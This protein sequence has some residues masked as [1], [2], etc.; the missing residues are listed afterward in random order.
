M[1]MVATT[2]AAAIGGCRRPGRG[3]FGPVRSPLSHK[4]APKRAP[5]DPDR[6]SIGV[7]TSEMPFVGGVWIAPDPGKFDLTKDN[8][9]HSRPCFLRLPWPG[10][11][12]FFADGH[13]VSNAPDL[14]LTSEVKRHRARRTDGAEVT[15]MRLPWLTLEGRASITSPLE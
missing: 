14:F 4:P 10:G 1:V 9:T 6:T 13:T 15:S 7:A 3:R 8:C 11:T 5:N 2:H 12:R